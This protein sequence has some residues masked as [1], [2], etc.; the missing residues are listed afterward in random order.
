V[1]GSEQDSQEAGGLSM[2]LQ[3]IGFHSGPTGQ[4]WHTGVSDVI[5]IEYHDRETLPVTDH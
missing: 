5:Q 4:P 1:S 2:G 3:I